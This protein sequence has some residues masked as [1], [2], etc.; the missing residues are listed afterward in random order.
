MEHDLTSA[1]ST[2]MDSPLGTRTR[3][4]KWTPTLLLAP[5][6]LIALL[7]LFVPK[8]TKNLMVLPSL[9][10][11]SFHPPVVFSFVFLAKCF[12]IFVIGSIF[13]NV[14]TSMFF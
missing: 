13:H 1:L 6:V 12:I 3:L 10:L 4:Q 2:P 11:N 7:F 9:V 5:S 14:L 8:G